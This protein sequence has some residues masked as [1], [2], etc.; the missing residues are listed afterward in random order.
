MKTKETCY[1]GIDRTILLEMKRIY[2]MLRKNPKQPSELETATMFYLKQVCED[3]ITRDFL[4]G[5]NE[6]TFINEL[7]AFMYLDAV[8]YLQNY[9]YFSTNSS[10]VEMLNLRFRLQ[11]IIEGR[12]PIHDVTED[13]QFA[14]GKPLDIN[15]LTPD[16]Y[17]RAAYE[18]SEGSDAMRRFFLYCFQNNFPTLASCAGHDCKNGSTTIPY[19]AFMLDG[20]DE[21]KK[22]YLMSKSYEAGMQITLIKLKDGKVMFDIRMDPFKREE[23]VESL[24]TFLEEYRGE[25]DFNPTLDNILNYV[26]NNDTSS[27]CISREKEDKITFEEIGRGHKVVRGCFDENYILNAYRTVGVKDSEKVIGDND[28]YIITPSETARCALNLTKKRP[29]RFAVAMKRALRGV[30]KMFDEDKTMV[31]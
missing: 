25:V 27:I 31:R 7:D 24:Q 16:N 29:G 5:S 23:Q 6:Y 15:D 28:A 12:E 21:D 17:E 10:D 11:R 13:S 8:S 18:F 4:Q 9:L 19:I 22:K 1:E 14:D 30:N 3:G 2:E 20:V 26:K